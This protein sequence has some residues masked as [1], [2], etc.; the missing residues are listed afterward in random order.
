[1]KCETY[2]TGVSVKTLIAY[3]CHNFTVFDSILQ[4]SSFRLRLL[5]FSLDLP[6]NIGLE[7]IKVS[8]G[9][10]VTEV[11]GVFCLL[12]AGLSIWKIIL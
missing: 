9:K 10:Q 5:I 8:R 6:V 12:L 7:Q 3:I 1:M 2:F 11:E 4:L